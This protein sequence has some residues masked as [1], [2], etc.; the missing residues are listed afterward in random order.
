MPKKLFNDDELKFIIE[1]INGKYSSELAIVFNKKFNRNITAK[2]IANYKKNYK[3]N[4][5]LRAN[6]LLNK[7]EHQFIVENAYGISTDE[8][9]EMFNQKF[10][11]NLQVKQIR[12]Y[13]EKHKITNG[14]NTKFKKG[15]KQI[16]TYSRPLGS[17]RVKYFNKTKETYI[18]VAHPKVWELKQNYMYKKY[19]GE[20][21][22]NS[23][24]IF[25]NGNRDDFSKENLECITL[26]EQYMMA[27][28]GLYFNDIDLTKTGIDIAKL[29]IKMKERKVK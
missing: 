27:C 8:L 24:V 10:N 16:Y 1:N 17:E 11:K 29:M 18:K 26:N 13:K 21:P 22:E 7:E 6:K 9:T 14:R 23:V 28:S 5:E 2:Q 20:M 12:N 15:Q 3:M 25:L 19:Y 4:S